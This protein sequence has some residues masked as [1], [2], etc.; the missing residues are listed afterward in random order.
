M[1]LSHIEPATPGYDK[2][3]FRCTVCGHQD[4]ITVAAE[5]ARGLR[6]REALLRDAAKMADES[7]G[8]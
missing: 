5:S 1:V 6:S 4:K 7:K 3:F 2:R 8:S